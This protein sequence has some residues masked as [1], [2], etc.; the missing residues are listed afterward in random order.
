VGCFWKVGTVAFEGLEDAI[1]R[2]LWRGRG[3]K[4]A[5]QAG[6]PT[7]RMMRSGHGNHRGR[8]SLRIVIG[9]ESLGLA[10]ES[11]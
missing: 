2:R 8:R 6:A 5:Q 7:K 1:G 11:K 9:G 3:R 10:A 4:R